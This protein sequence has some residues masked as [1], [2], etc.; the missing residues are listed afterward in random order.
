MM[1][2]V[3]WYIGVGNAFFRALQRPRQD[4][5]LEIPPLALLG[6][7][8]FASSSVVSPP[9]S[10]TMTDGLREVD[11]EADRVL[12][13]VKAIVRRGLEAETR[14]HVSGCSARRLARRL[15]NTTQQ[16]S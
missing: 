12:L 15:A 1:T 13:A 14:A 6:S 16:L 2:F 3:D 11:V 5:R 9:L 8:N 4:S 7:Q 10:C